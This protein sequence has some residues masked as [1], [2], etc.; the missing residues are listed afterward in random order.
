MRSKVSEHGWPGSSRE[1]LQMQMS[2]EKDE[3]GV[4]KKQETIFMKNGRFDFDFESNGSEF[5]ALDTT[6]QGMRI[7]MGRKFRN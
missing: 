2:V 3:N 7:Y 1:T 5:I 4:A 6:V